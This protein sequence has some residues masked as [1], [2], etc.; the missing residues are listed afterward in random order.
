MLRSNEYIRSLMLRFSAIPVNEIIQ[1]QTLRSIDVTVH[2]VYF[3]ISHG[4]NLLQMCCGAGNQWYIR[5]VDGCKFP[6]VLLIFF[7][8]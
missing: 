8:E 1:I 7:I 3:S 4:T 2:D 6:R 5:R